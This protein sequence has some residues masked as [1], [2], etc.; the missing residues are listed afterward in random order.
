MVAKK[1][2]LIVMEGIDGSGK[3]VQIKLLSDW[4]KAKGMRTSTYAYPDLGS[5]CGELLN[6]YLKGK[7][8]LDAKTQLLAFA[9]DIMKDQDGIADKICRGEA[10]LLDRY[11]PSTVAYQC[12]KGFPCFDAMRLFTMLQPLKPDAIV[13]LDVPPA[14]GVARKRARHGVRK[15]DVHD[16]DLALLKKVRTNYARLAEMKWMCRKWARVNSNKPIEETS[17]EIRALITSLVK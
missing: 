10:V 4:L 5:K 16:S 12:A 11:I 13:W 3:A 17:E 6:D 8:A 7:V 9:T 15:K 14:V 2:L 1:G